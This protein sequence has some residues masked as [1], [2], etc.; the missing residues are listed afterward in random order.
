MMLCSEG[1][2]GGGAGGPGP[3]KGLARSGRHPE[4]LSGRRGEEWVV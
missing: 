1:H 2:W 4:D 3:T